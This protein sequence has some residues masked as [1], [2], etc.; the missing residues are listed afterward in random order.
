M[1]I[2]LPPEIMTIIFDYLD[3]KSA[4]KARQ[5][6]RL[7]VQLFDDWVINRA[8][9]ANFSVN[10]QHVTN[11]ALRA[12]DLSPHN[13]TY[14]DQMNDRKYTMQS[15][16]IDILMVNS[17]AR[18]SIKGNTIYGNFTM[19][20]ISPTKLA[21][22]KSADPLMA[23]LEAMAITRDFSPI[24]SAMGTDKGQTWPKGALSDEIR[25]LVKANWH[26]A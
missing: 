22:Y 19:K 11:W 15:P 1:D 2:Y 16:R 23:L 9:Y 4:F 26:K 6:C 20:F 3:L 25:A 17:K 21:E 8:I 13:I 5:C 24:R 14:I 12:I 10:S 18:Y 7:F